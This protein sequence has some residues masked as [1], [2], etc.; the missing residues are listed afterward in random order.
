MRA[1]YCI[2]FRTGGHAMFKW[3]HSLAMTLDE[4]RKA[5]DAEVRAGRPE[6]FIARYSQVM[7]HG[8]PETFA[9]GNE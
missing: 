8:V 4:A 9:R 3:R 5:L 2:V 7:T 1:D 6:S